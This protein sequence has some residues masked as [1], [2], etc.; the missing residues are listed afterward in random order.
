MGDSLEKLIIVRVAQHLVFNNYPGEL[1]KPTT[2]PSIGATVA[3]G[4]GDCVPVW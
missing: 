2:E 1:P 4:G 3:Q